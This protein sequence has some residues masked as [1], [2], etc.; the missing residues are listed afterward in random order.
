MPCIKD[1]TNFQGFVWCS[2]ALGSYFAMDLKRT[3]YVEVEILIKFVDVTSEVEFSPI[4][5]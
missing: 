2:R 1:S 4:L 3:C 5:I